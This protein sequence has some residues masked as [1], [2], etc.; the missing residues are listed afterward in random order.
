[1]AA[2]ARTAVA[3][4]GSLGVAA[5]LAAVAFVG[6]ARPSEA[7]LWRILSIEAFFAGL[8]L[9]LALRLGGS[10]RERLGLVR[11]QFGWAPLALGSLGTLALSGALRFAVDALALAPG[12]SLE[13][14]DAAAAE[15]ARTSP[16][17]VLA[18]FA[19]APPFAEELLCRG[20]L[21]RSLARAI[22]AWAIPAAAL[23]FAALHLDAVHSPA[24]FLL[25]VYLGALAWLS[26][27]SWLPIGCHFANNALASLEP[28]VPG[29]SAAV[30]RPSSWVEA[31]GAAALALAA[32]A[33]AARCCRGD[34]PGRCEPSA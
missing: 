4:A 10:V 11:A 5:P 6:H 32:L 18:A 34:A 12:S 1:V 25:G 23:A 13:R 16:L 27:S 31:G 19:L 8:A 21:Q 33:L 28:L 15:A 20:V 9:L 14:L 24:A 22:G 2:R 26:G 30:P 29:I 7:A 17:L 3:L